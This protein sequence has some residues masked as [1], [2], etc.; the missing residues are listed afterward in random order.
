MLAVLDSSNMETSVQQ[1]VSVWSI[2]R[3]DRFSMKLPGSP[4]QGIKKHYLDTLET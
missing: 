2:E 4:I 3:C 1:H